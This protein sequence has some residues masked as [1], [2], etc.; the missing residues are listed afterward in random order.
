MAIRRENRPGESFLTSRPAPRV[1]RP[2]ATPPTDSG[3]ERMAA[4]EVYSDESTSAAG[5]APGPSTRTRPPLTLGALAARVGEMVW[6]EQRLFEVLGFW[7]SIEPNAELAVAFAEA[8]RHHG[9]HASLWDE[10]RP[11]AVGLQDDAVV[12]P[13]NEGW[14]SLFEELVRTA[15]PDRS[16]DR[17]SAILR[18]VDPWLRIRDEQISG[19]LT[20]LSD[21]ALMRSQRFMAIDHEDSS[22]RL[23]QILPV[24]PPAQGQAFIDQLF[25]F[26]S[27]NH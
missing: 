20:P 22:A 4:S 15:Q 5:A 13:P 12:Q 9:W 7:S 18:V 10:H 19:G 21:R 8:S 3:V 24:L 25:S 17:V 2:P 27:D 16:A 23:R 1:I 6:L 14:V 11:D 26:I